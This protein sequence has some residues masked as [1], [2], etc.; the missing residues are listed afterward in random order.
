MQLG[1]LDT[2]L[3]SIGRGSVFYTPTAWDFNSNLSTA[4]QFL[5]FTEGEITQVPNESYQTLTLDEYTG[6]APHK[7]TVQGEA[8]V[9]TIPLFTA[10]PAL[11]AIVSP[12]G[13]SSGGSKRQQPVVTRSLVILPEELFIDP[14]DATAQSDLPLTYDAAQDRWEL[15][16]V[17][18]TEAQEDLL[19]QSLWIWKGYFSKPPLT[20][21]H[22]NVGKS[23]D[24]C[25]FTV[26][27]QV[28][29]PN[30]SRLYHIGDPN[31]VVNVATGGLVDS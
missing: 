9:L 2:I 4:L 22:E 31:E 13:T 14:S 24:E 17:A 16:T 10:D 18:L 26:M 27:Y 30:G 23:V 12:T 8:P 19:G 5:G 1:D 15:G 28:A 3:A 7:A 11:R 29:A 25:T 20:Y 6:G 21:R